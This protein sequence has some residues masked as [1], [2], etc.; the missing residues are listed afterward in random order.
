MNRFRAVLIAALRRTIPNSDGVAAVEFALLA[1]VLIA[2]FFGTIEI[3]NGFQCRRQVVAMAT[4]AA[5]LVAQSTQLN[6]SDE[7]N[8]FSALISI[9][10]PNTTS[11]ASII[12]TSIIDNGKGGYAVAWSDAQNGTPHPVGSTMAVPAGLIPSGGSVILAEVTYTYHSPT[13]VTITG[14]IT[15]STSAY[16]APRLSSQVARV[17]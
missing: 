17:P 5:D 7:A 13:S 8:I 12:L 16:S 9:L 4:T 1:P 15:F 2:L 14:P 6:N 3:A 11:S 10:Y